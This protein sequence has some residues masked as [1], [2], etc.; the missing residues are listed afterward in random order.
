[1]NPGKY[2]RSSRF[3]Y[4]QYSNNSNQ[5]NNYT[6]PANTLDK[7]YEVLESKQT[8]SLEVIK[9]NYRRLVK[10]YH[11]DSIASKDL[12]EAMVKFA[13]EKTQSLNEAYA[14]IKEARG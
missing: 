4:R 8:D 5:Y 7:Y 12:P 2:S 10:E 11:Y 13:Q 14:A 1:M 3:E 9:A 6:R